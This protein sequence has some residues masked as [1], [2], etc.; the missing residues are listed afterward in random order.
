MCAPGDAAVL[1]CEW[2][3]ACESVR[4]GSNGDG[5]VNVC[6]AR[7]CLV[8]SEGRADAKLMRNDVEVAARLRAEEQARRLQERQMMR[9]LLQRW[10]RW[11]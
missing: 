1:T 6:D 10:L 2:R 3:C 9:E 11:A 7:T 5:C 4:A 8:H